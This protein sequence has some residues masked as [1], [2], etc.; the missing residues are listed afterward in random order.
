MR[1]KRI[2][3]GLMTLA[4][5][6]FVVV[7]SAVS[8][9]K[10]HSGNESGSS[11]VPR[12]KHIVEIMME[13]T[14]YATVIGNS[15]APNINA[16]ANQYG[17]ATNYFGVTHPSEPNYVANI[18]GSFF[19]IQDDNQFYCTPALATTDPNCAGTTVDHTVSN[20]SLAD[21]LTAAGKTWKG[22]F[23][24]MP[25]VD[26]SKVVSSGPNAN[27]PYTFK[28]P[29]NTDALYASKHNPFLNFTGTQ[30]DLSQ[31][32]PDNQL[33]ADLLTGHLPNYSLVVPDQCH[34]MHGIAACS[35]TNALIQ[36]GDQ[37]VGTTVSEVMASRT[38][39]EGNNAIVIT[40]DED[41][42]SDQGKPGT[43]CCGADPGG[44]HVVTI[45]ITNHGPGHVTDNTAYNHY[46]LLRTF[47]AAFG[48][49]CLQH[50]CDSVVPTM[51]PLFANG[52][53]NS[54]GSADYNR[55]RHG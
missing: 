27:G 12:Y 2:V 32:V 14:S 31:M 25:Y 6:A 45:V 44:G 11:S 55:H 43:G 50:A 33:G 29:S 35:D 13:N 17:L 48:L 26:P 28:W 7:P 9:H 54:H 4:G 46:S 10:S 23:Q 41:D 49:P 34:D 51:A 38:W 40:W 8:A 1:L 21:Q 39:K 47:E 52:R 16:L 19:G 53:R 3:F 18:G 36:A 5:V 22:Y 37:Y 30:G 15:N 24:N 20:Q 42:F